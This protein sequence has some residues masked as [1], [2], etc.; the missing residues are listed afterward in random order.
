LLFCLSIPINP[1]RAK[2]SMIFNKN[3]KKSM[4]NTSHS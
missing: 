2:A 3:T 1:P 4:N